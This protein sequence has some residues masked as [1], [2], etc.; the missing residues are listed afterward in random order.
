MLVTRGCSGDLDA[1]RVRVRPR[2]RA[3]AEGVEQHDRREEDPEDQPP[4]ITVAHAGWV[5]HPPRGCQSPASRPC[6]RALRSGTIPIVTRIQARIPLPARLVAS[7]D[8]IRRRFSPAHARGNPAHVTLAYQDEAPDP[9]L[10]RERLRLAAART[11]RFELSIGRTKRFEPPVSG[12][13]LDVV[14]PAGVVA[15]LRDRLLAPPFSPRA[16]FALHV[17]IVHPAEAAL[18]SEAWPQLGTLVFPGSFAVEGL[19][20]V[21]GSNTVVTRFPLAA[22]AASR[23]A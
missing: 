19:E 9:H 8:P 10:L 7:I 22:A 3:Q 1:R 23:T 4:C 2:A 16:R 14:D 11:P 18:L 13:Y 6:R 17:T 12:A 21:D 20:L 5:R 15:G